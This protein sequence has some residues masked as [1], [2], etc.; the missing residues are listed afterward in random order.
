M[1]T[2]SVLRKQWTPYAVALIGAGLVVL[3]AWMSRGKLNPVIAGQE[4]PEFSA[5]DV[6]GVS[7]SSDDYRG[8]VL[9]V[10]IWATWCE[11]CKEEMPSM[12]R[13]FDQLGG[14]DF[15]ILA[16]SVDAPIG[17]E[18]LRFGLPGGNPFAYADSLSLTFP[19]L[20]DPSARI[21]QSYRI[22]GVP[23]SFVIDRDGVIIRKV[24]GP[25]DWDASGY[26]ELFG[27]LLEH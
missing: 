9:L 12:Q 11:T 23:E 24:S 15:Q 21:A 20:H 18:D 27:R 17:Q 25:A 3:V 26:V 14:D 6:Q 22:T 19:I 7:R 4:A 13:L 10:N 5:L 16:V 2:T 8:K 1:L